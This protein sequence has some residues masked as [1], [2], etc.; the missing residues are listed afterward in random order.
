MLITT[1]IFYVVA[2]ERFGWRK[3]RALALCGVFLVVDL[4]FLGSTSFK[5]PDG[6]WF[7]LLAATVVFTLLATWRTGRRLVNARLIGSRLPLARFIAGIEDRPVVRAPGTGAYLF[8]HPGMTPPTL[9][10]SLRHHDSLHEQVLVISVVTEERPRVHPLQRSEVTDLGHGFHQVVLRYGFMEDP[11]VPA[12]LAH[13]AN[14]QIGCDLD[15][16]T[17]FVGRES[18][19]V[20]PRPGMAWWRERLF[21]LMWR[22]S[23]SAATYLK[24]P[25]DQTVEIGVSV[26]L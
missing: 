7:P 14:M 8:R 5:I 10:A 13:R 11:D 4:G 6:G 9:L 16:M 1:I 15:T 20:T 17:Y 19:R 23:T 22:N 26:E 18:V 21:A 2:R 3:S 24:L 12:D 25:F